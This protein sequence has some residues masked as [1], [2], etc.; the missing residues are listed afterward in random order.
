MLVTIHA[1]LQQSDRTTTGPRRRE[2]VRR[3]TL[4]RFQFARR[5][6]LVALPERFT[7]KEDARCQLEIVKAA[8]KEK[9]PLSRVRV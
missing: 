8:S 4:H 3:E 2:N 9:S 5:R 6:D 7:I 1:G